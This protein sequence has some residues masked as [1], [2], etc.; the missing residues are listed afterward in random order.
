MRTSRTRPRVGRGAGAK[1]PRLSRRE[2]E[3]KA[4]RQ[5]MLEAAERVFVAK[6]LEHA[7][8]ADVAEEADFSVGALYNF[9]PGKDALFGEVMNNIATAFEHAF[10]RE[11]AAS[12][13]SLEA[14]RRVAE[15][16]F[17]LMDE[18][19]AFFRRLVELRPA[20]RAFP[21]EAIPEACRRRY[22]VYLRKLEDLFAGAILEGALRRMEP[23]YA[24]LTFEGAINAYSAYWVRE[25]VDLPLEERVRVLLQH[26]LEPM[27]TRKKKGKIH[28]AGPS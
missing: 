3:R 13:S 10:Q 22:A 23:R 7:T 19:G 1:R 18:H 4:H 21:D 28:E 16:R 6:G 17:R 8:M 9:F 2:R 24:A 12:P 5:Q 26:C 14:L 25:G 27:R 15:L 11:V 20:G